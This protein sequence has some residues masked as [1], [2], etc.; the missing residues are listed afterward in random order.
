M[1][2]LQLA[3]EARLFHRP[4][5]TGPAYWGPGDH[6]TFLVTGEESGGAYFA[7]EA[8]VPPGGG[9]PPHIHR[10]EDETFYLLEGEIRFRLG[11]ETI[12]AGPG[13]F[14]NVPRGTVHNFTNAGSETARM[15]LTFTPAGMERFFEETLEPAPNAAE[16]APDNLDE[17][18]ARYV[19]AAPDYGLEFV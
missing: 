2:A 14:V 13:D 1:S 11:D 9:P 15:V 4:V 8:L 7:M 12:T 5:A 17:V 3:T 6:Y 18:A 19:A 10:R 16:G